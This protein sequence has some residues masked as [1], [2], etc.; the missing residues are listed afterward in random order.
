M[1]TTKTLESLLK[2]D[3]AIM[4]AALVSIS[5]VAWLYMGHEARKMTHTGVCEC[6]GLKVSAPDLQRWGAIELLGLFLMWSEMMVAMMIPA[7]APMIL[8]FAAVNRRRREQEQ[9]FVPTSIFLFGYL[10]V[11]MSFSAVATVA[12]WGLHRTALLSPMMVSTSPLLGGTLLIAAGGFQWTPLKHR[13]VAH[14][15]S[16]LSFLMSDWREGKSGA[17]RM[18]LKHG[19]YCTGCCW[20]L[21]L[22]LFV[23]GVMNVWWIAAIAFFVLLEKI[24]S[25][26][27]PLSRASG[28][29]LLVWGAWLIVKQA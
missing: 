28:F 17:L 5:A 18:G 27:L 19:A 6:F 21:M 4:G 13:C 25:R 20:V 10:L 22:L 9:P 11:W 7:A 16:P 24:C 8:T 1:G 14:C 3:R 29:G 2:R 26:T 15:R 23:L 12:Q